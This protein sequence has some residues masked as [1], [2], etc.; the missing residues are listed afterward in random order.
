MTFKPR[1][2]PEIH[3]HFGAVFTYT[4]LKDGK[5]HSSTNWYPTP[6]AR[7]RAVAAALSPGAL[8]P[9]TKVKLKERV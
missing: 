4:S 8:I 7:E 9:V 6:K 1:R 5:V 2:L 3:D